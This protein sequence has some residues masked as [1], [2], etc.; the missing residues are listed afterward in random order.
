[1]SDDVLDRAFIDAIRAVV[2]TFEGEHEGRR[3]VAEYRPSMA[4]SVHERLGDDPTA[5]S[6]LMVIG[7][8]ADLV[9]RLTVDGEAVPIGRSGFR[10]E[11]VILLENLRERITEHAQTWAA[12][13]REQNGLYMQRAVRD[14]TRPAPPSPAARRMQRHLRRTK[15]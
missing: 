2:L 6:A 12:E 7:Y 9:V 10:L 15:R 4:L 8:F 1:M 11:T 13:E 3:V 5:P 14:A